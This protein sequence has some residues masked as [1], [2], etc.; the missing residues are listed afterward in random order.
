MPDLRAAV[1]SISLSNFPTVET[2]E[3][4]R[5]IPTSS[6]LILE[7]SLKRT[8]TL[9]L[10]LALLVTIRMLMYDQ[11]VLR[12]FRE[13]D[14]Q[15]EK[16][17]VLRALGS[18]NDKSLLRRYLSPFPFCSDLTSPPQHPGV[19]AVARGAQPGRCVRDRERR[20]QPA[21]AAA[22]VG[23]H[24]RALGRPSAALRR[25]LPPHASDPDDR[26]LRQRGKGPGKQISSERANGVV[27]AS[28]SGSVLLLTFDHRKWRRSSR[29]TR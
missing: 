28:A 15:E 29:R 20:G 16:V 14:M 22:R 24:P 10:T 2:Y 3:V 11:A 1:Y 19:S 8:L 6:T 25:R 5:L 7:L 17:R 9:T 18:V 27:C 12:V 23:L 13:A 4:L 21:R 26:G